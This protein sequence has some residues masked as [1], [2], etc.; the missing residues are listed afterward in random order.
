MA[1]DTP[2]HFRL[3]EAIPLEETRSV[4][5]KEVKG[6]NPVAAII[7]AADEYAVAFMN[8]EGGVIYWGVQDVGHRVVGVRLDSGQRDDLR[9]KVAGKLQTILPHINPARLRLTLHRVEGCNPEDELFVVELVVPAP[10]T[11]GPY[12][13]SGSDLFIR[14]EGVTQK[15]VGPQMTEWIKGHLRK[16]TASSH[17]VAE[18]KLMELV[19]RVRRVFEAHGL[20]PAHLGRFLIQQKAPFSISFTDIQTDGAFL[21]W[22]DSEKIDWISQTFL[23]RREWIEGEDDRIHEDHSFDKQPER[24]F[25]TIS[26]HTDA[27]IYQDLMAQPQAYFIQWGL[28]GEWKG[29]GESRVFVVV[30]V[31]LAQI[32]GARQA[33]AEDLLADYATESQ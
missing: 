16:Q 9:K 5:F 8:S 20:E 6:G 28:G 7:N 27:L 10:D 32:G 12:Y 14:L 4:E 19:R 22:L 15:L 18:P 11:P 17:S 33:M 29:K 31:P 3:G 26:R 2:P 25:S 30:A 21:A 23:I 13:T 24:F 1:Q